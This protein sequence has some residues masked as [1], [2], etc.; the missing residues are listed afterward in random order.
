MENALTTATAA[1]LVIR[2]GEPESNA[3]VVYLRRY[4]SPN[5]IRAYHAALAWIAARLLDDPAADPLTFDWAQLRYSHCQALRADLARTAS[6]ATA[7]LRITVLRGVLREAWRLGQLDADAYNRATDLEPIRG[8]RLPSGRALTAGEIR[9]LFEA[10][11]RRGL[12]GARDAAILAAGYVGGLRRAEIAG[13][14][15]SDFNAET[16]ALRIRAGKGNQDRIAYLGNGAL[17]AL[18]DW[19][20]C[21]EVTEGPLF[22]AV[23]KG[24]RMG[25]ARL[26]PAAIL[27]ALEALAALAGVRRFS[28]HDLRRSCA[29]DLLDNGVDLATVADLLGHAK[30][31]TT[32]RY[33]RRPDERKRQA[34]RTLHCPY[35]GT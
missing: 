22:V 18:R 23:G 1:G 10:C 9:A 17:E 5:T 29:S 24:G 15:L 6:P 3:A 4:P 34:V 30:V 33:D 2:T 25:A 11:G 21:R 26:T 20:A 35:V 16:G 28:P 27:K 12:L 32:R 7:N 31:E 19:A 13:L 14:D 8:S